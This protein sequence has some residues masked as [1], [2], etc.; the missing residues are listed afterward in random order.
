VRIGHISIDGQTL[1][2]DTWLVFASSVTP[3][4]RIELTSAH[5]TF[6]LSA[7]PNGRVDLLPPTAS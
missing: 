1:P 2:Q 6:V 3:L 4:F 7:R 5:G